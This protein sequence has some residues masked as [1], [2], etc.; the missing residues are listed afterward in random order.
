M[1]LLVPADQGSPRQKAIKWLCVSQRAFIAK[2]VFPNSSP[3]TL[4]YNLAIKRTNSVKVNQMV[5]YIV[6]T[7]KPLTDSLPRPQKR[8]VNVTKLSNSVN[9]K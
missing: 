6:Q 5:K 9:N 7:Y 2:N 8:S 4:A 1:F 3:C